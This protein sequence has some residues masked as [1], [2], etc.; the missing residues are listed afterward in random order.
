MYTLAEV[1]HAAPV[2]VIVVEGHPGVHY[3]RRDEARHLHIRVSGLPLS[4]EL[5]TCKT[6]KARY[7]PWLSGKGL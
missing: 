6:V 4:S 1:V 2:L 7:R 5:D 3:L